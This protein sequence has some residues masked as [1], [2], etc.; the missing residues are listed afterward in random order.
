MA[1]NEVDS[2]HWRRYMFLRADDAADKLFIDRIGTSK[3]TA[4]YIEFFYSKAAPST[5]R[6]LVNYN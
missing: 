1:N 5:L 4:T 2:T 3:I 6:S